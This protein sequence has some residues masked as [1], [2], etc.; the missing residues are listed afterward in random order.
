[1]MLDESNPT[2]TQLKSGTWTGLAFADAVLHSGPRLHDTLVHVTLADTLPADTL[3]EG[4]FYLTDTA[5]KNPSGYQ[6][7][8]RHGGG[9]HQFALS[10][11]VPASRH[12]RFELRVTTPDGSPAALLHRTATGPYWAV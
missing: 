4:R 5:G 12:L 2:D 8:T 10:G 9:G 1:M 11:R 3:V 7:V 6:V